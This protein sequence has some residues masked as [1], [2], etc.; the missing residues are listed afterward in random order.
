MAWFVLVILVGLAWANGLHGEFTYDDKVEV[1]GNRTIRFLEQWRAMLGY[2]VSRP[3]V[4][5]TYALNHHFSGSDPF[6]YHLVDVIIQAVNAGLAM[7]LLVEFGAFRGCARPLRLGVLGAAFWAVHPLSTEAVTYVTGRS[8]QLVAMFVL[9][10]CWGWMR[11]L[12]DGSLETWAWCW[13]GVVAAGMTKENGVVLPVLMLAIE[14]LV[15][16][17]GCFRDVRWRAYLPGLFFFSLFFAYR[18]WRY[19]VFTTP[20]NLRELPVQLWTQAEV[21]VRY[22]QLVVLPIGQSV[23]HDHPETGMTARSVGS[24]VIL[25]T[26]SVLAWVFR[27]KRPLWALAWVWFLVVLSPSSSFVPLKET[28]AEHRAYLAF[29]GPCWVLALGVDGLVQVRRMSVALVLGALLIGLTHV[30]NNVWASEVSLWKEVVERN[31]ESAEGWYGYGEAQRFALAKLQ[32]E[33]PRAGT[34]RPAEAYRR[35]AELNPDL[36]DAWNNLGLSEANL[37]NDEAAVQAWQ[38]ALKR[39]PTY[40]KAHNNMGLLHARRDR[41]TDAVAEFQAGLLYCPENDLGLYFLGKLYDEKLDE[42][43]KAVLAWEALLKEH[44]D[45]VHSEEVRSRILELTW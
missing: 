10:T 11:W 5:T 43:D 3:V 32:V 34:Y 45:F 36:L 4:I 28:M 24:V 38:Q 33:D 41:L 37:G 27:R 13:V 42:P 39:S 35:S 16:R 20:H 29:L 31:P 22:L 23:F 26:L 1:I 14:Y 18:H 25:L 9:W 6:A 21:I 7:L 44:P 2:N 19:G 40:C 12:R 8:E 15:V 30:R 17:K